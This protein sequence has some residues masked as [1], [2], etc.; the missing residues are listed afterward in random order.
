MKSIS[1]KILSSTLL[2]ALSMPLTALAADQDL[3]QKVDS[4]SKEL[5]TLKQQVKRTEDKSL[6][7]WLTIGGD[8]RFRIDSLQGKTKAFTDVNRT[9]SFAQQQMNNGF[10]SDPVNFGPSVLAFSN[11]A[12]GMNQVRT[13]NGANAFLGNPANQAMLGQLQNFAQMVPAQTVKNDTLYTNRLGLD[14]HAKATKDVTVNVRLVAYKTFGSL[15]DSA[16]TGSGGT[17]FFADRVGVFDG[18]IGHVPSSDFLGVDRA[19]ATWSN[20]AEQPVWFSVG[21]RP[22]TNG[23]PSHLRMNNEK[24]GNGGTPALLVD[25]AFDGMTLGWAPD[26]DM[27]P[28]AYA[29]VCYGRGFEAGVDT[30]NSSGNTLR[31]T[32]MLGVAVIPYDT[33]PLR[34]SFQWNRGF[35]IFDFPVM[36]NTAFGDTAPTVE[37]GSIDWYELGALS[38][39]KNIGPGTLNLFGS[40]GLSVTHPNDNVSANAGF[41]GLLTGQFFNPE[42]PTDK[43]GWAA[44]VGAR[45]DYTPTRTKLGFEYNHGSKNWITFAPAADDMWTSKVGTRG[46]VYEGYVIQE[47]NLQPVSSY[48]SKTFF[49]LGYQYYDF[50]YTGSN[51]WVGAPQKIADLQASSMQLLAPLKSA[52]NIYFTFEVKF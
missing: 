10:L 31:D 30:P 34:I 3:Q 2:L 32:D 5:E 6:G 22:S 51:N 25:Y 29:K 8:Y 21:R 43:T 35:N 36:N 23:V 41:Q 44:Y 37:L 26:F 15:D 24:P 18:T 33:D 9:F 12:A 47:L 42:A 45:Y 38:T 4:M 46:N 17:P 48:L 40:F 16:V 1:K 52:Q 7:K 20:I 13:F 19:Y 28:G 14:L 11:F 50:E 39:Q 49:R 27:L